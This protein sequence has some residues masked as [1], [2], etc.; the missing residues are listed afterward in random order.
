MKTKVIKLNPRDFNPEDLKEPAEALASGQLTAFPTETVYGIGADAAK[1]GA[2]ADLLKIKQS[3]ADKPLTIHMA[4]P[5]D[6][7]PYTAKPPATAIKLMKKFWPGPLTIIIPDKN[8]RLTGFRVP[9]CAITRELIRMSGVHIAATSANVSGGADAVNADD[10]LK[11]FDGKISFLIDSGETQF[12]KPSTIVKIAAQSY[13]IIREGVIPASLIKDTA[14]MT[15]LFVCTG[16]SCRSP[17]AEGLLKKMLAKRLNI[18]PEELEDNGYRI[19]SAGTSA[20]YGGRASDNAITIMKEMGADIRFHIARPVTNQM[21]RDADKIFVMSRVHKLI[22]SEEF[23]NCA[24]K[25]E[26]LD[27]DNSDVEDP[28]GSPIE[29]YRQCARKIK[30]LL[31]AR[32]KEL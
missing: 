30:K 10:V 27:P 6:I 15:I 19:I 29:T 31:E 16:N 13:E 32:L 8:E 28:V 1:T 23:P 12:K 2:V 20:M 7:T 3:P 9:S 4:N 5:N 22:L 17:M 26:L 18:T 11:E 25:M 14:N 21:V 24:A